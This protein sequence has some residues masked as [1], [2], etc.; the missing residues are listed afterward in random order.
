MKKIYKSLLGI[1]YSYGL[2]SHFIHQDADSLKMRNVYMHLKEDDV[3]IL[4]KAHIARLISNIISL[5]L[6]RVEIFIR[7]NK[8]NIEDYSGEVNLLLGYC[9]DLEELNSSLLKEKI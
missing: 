2:S 5:S 9:K 3:A 6:M 8:L 4:D 7:V 1:V